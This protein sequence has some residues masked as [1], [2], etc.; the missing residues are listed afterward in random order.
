[1]HLNSAWPKLLQ[2]SVLHL[3]H[4][5]VLASQRRRR[6]SGTSYE[7]PFC[8]TL[9]IER[10]RG[11]LYLKNFCE[12]LVLAYISQRRWHKNP[13]DPNI[14]WLVPPRCACSWCPC[15]N[16]KSLAYWPL[17]SPTD[18]KL[19]LITKQISNAFLARDWTEQNFRQHPYPCLV[20]RC[21]VFYNFTSFVLPKLNHI[22]DAFESTWWCYLSTDSP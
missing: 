20:W 11:N 4:S 8:T 9:T 3:W 2:R 19:I 21:T 17:W 15:M 22:D 6:C 10:L 16:S 18:P 12:N 13:R 7:H 1:M 5:A 14:V